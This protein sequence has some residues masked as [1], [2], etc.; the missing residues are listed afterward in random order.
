MTTV[1][2]GIISKNKN[3]WFSGFEEAIKK[4]NYSY[5]VIEIDRN[6]WLKQIEDVD[7]I[8]S[9][10]PLKYIEEGREK[11]Y[12]MEKILHKN[13]YPNQD[14]YWHYDNKNAQKYLSEIYNNIPLPKSFVSYSYS[15]SLNYIKNAK[16][17]LVSKSS[18]GASSRNVRLLNNFGEAKKELDYIFG[19]G[20]LNSYKEKIFQ[21]TGLV[22]NKYGMQKRYVHYQEFIPNNSG[23]LKIITI[24][25]KFAYAYYRGNRENDFR[26]SGSGKNNYSPELHHMDAIKY[27]LKVSKENNFDSM[28]YDLLFTKEGFVTSEI[29]FTTVEKYLYKCQGYYELADDVLKFNPGHTWPQE[30][31]LTY[32]ERKWIGEKIKV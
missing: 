28:G 32:L 29:S 13:V 20:K 15:D 8:I 2:F 3:Y 4:R 1:D 5:K 31:I 19:I 18:H 6:D 26:A 24:G 11:L 14:T 10:F 9:R 12:I 17:P 30:L 23:D 25:D 27:F 21:K 16:Y 7:N 22:S